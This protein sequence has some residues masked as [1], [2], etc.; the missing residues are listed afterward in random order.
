MLTCCR[1]GGMPEYVDSLNKS[2]ENN[3]QG[4]KIEE[5]A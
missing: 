3:F 1:A 4:W 2:L 5:K